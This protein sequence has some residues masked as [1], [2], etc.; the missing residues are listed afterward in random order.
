[1]STAILNKWIPIRDGD[2]RALG[3]YLRHY[4]ARK[5][6]ATRLWSKNYNRFAA[7]GENLILLTPLCDALFVWSKQ[8][9]R[10]DDQYGVNCAVFRNEGPQLSS[11]LIST[12]SELA[13]ERWPGE[14]LFT[15]VDST[16]I[17]SSNPGYCFVMA[18]WRRCGLSNKGLVILERNQD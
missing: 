8:L 7:P 2:P 18:G 5:N 3:L 10:L 6:G 17:R 14:R 9:Y 1:M 4:S 16:K 11:D 13:W 15:F 12:A